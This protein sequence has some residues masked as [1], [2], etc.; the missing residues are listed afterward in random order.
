MSDFVPNF[1]LTVFHHQEIRSME[2]EASRRLIKARY[3]MS[4]S[5]LNFK[6]VGFT[7]TTKT[8]MEKKKSL[9]L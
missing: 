6:F 5:L 1:K 7:P 3:A 2:M 4:D 8:A 9:V